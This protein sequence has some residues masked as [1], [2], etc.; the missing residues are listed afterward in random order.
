M[1]PTAEPAAL[2][3]QLLRDPRRLSLSEQ[4]TRD[5]DA[6][7]TG[8]ELRP[9]DRLPTER[10][11]M[12]RY[13]VSRT[14]V[15]EAMSSLRAAGRLATQ[16]GRGAFVLAPAPQALAY[17]LHPSEADAAGDMLALMEIRIALEAEAASLAAQRRDEAGLAAL[18]RIAEDFEASIEDPAQSALH[19]RDFH[20]CVA[21]LSG[22]AY[23]GSL[24][25][26][27]GSGLPPRA[28]IDLFKEDAAARLAYLRLLQVEHGNILDA[29]RRADA[30]GARAAMRLHLTHSRERLRAALEGLGGACGPE[31]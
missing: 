20:L 28:R 13:G 3:L 24:L 2:A 25:G 12:A 31:G 6:R 8:G 21:R 19:D 29:I 4:V 16:Q 5:L 22:N 14:V 1:P 27:L 11:L 17:R 23:F 26:G 15:R 9:G 10:E 18:T 7:I 30:E